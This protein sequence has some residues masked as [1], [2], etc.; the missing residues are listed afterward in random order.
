MQHLIN[1]LASGVLRP[2]DPLVGALPPASPL[3][4]QPQIPFAALPQ[5]DLVDP[6]LVRVG[7]QIRVRL[8]TD[9][10]VWLGVRV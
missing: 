4:A 1:T 7:A 8:S 6:Q 3:G 9:D 5:H 10:P 2:T